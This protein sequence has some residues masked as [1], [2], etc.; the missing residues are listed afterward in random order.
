MKVYRIN[1]RSILICLALLLAFTI[2]S[3]GQEEYSYNYSEIADHPRLLLNRSGEQTVKTVVKSTPE[4]KKINDYI[5]EQSDVIL[6]QK[7]VH[8]EKRGKRLLWVS[9]IALT[10]LYYLSYS[11]RITGETKYLERAELELNT[12]ADFESWNPSHFLDIGEMTMAVAIAY[13]WL[14]DGLKEETKKNVREAIVEK[15][16][17]PSYIEKY[18]WFLNKHSN[19]NS[20]CNAGLVFG[21]LAIMEDEPEQSIAII[22]RALVSNRLP[23]EVFAPDGNY[24]EGP[25]Y[26][27]Y[28]TSF[29]VMLIAALESALGSDNGLSQAPGFMRTAEYI[30]F[31]SGPSG[32]Y[33]NYYDC[34][35]E[36][37]ARSSIFWFA[38]KLNNPSLVYQELAM[39]RD[40]GYTKKVSSDIERIL[41]N[42]IVFGRN[43]NLENIPK[44]NVKTFTGHGITPVTIVRTNWEGTKGKYMGIKGGSASDGHSHMDQGTFVYDVG[45][46]RWAMDLGLQSYGTL[47]SEGVD[48]WSMTQNSQR[49]DVFRYNNLNHNTISINGQKHNIEGRAKIVETYDDGDELGAKVDLTDV[50]NLNNEVKNATRKVTIVKDSYLKVEDIIEANEEAVKIRWNMVTPSKAEKVNKNTIRL[51]QKG[52][53]MFLKVQSKTSFKIAIRESENPSTVKCDFT[54]RKYEDYNHKNIG[55]V[56]VGFDAEVP[57]GE[58]AKFTVTLTEGPSDIKLKK[59]TIV[60]DAPDPSTASEGDNFFMDVSPF[61]IDGDGYVFAKE[62][63]DWTPYGMVSIPSAV[64]KSFSFII[65]AKRIEDSGLVDAGID[66]AANGQLGIRGGEN[67]GIENNEGYIFGL[68]LSEIDPSVTFELTKIQLTFFDRTESCIIVNRQEA[69]RMKSLSGGDKSN[70]AFVKVTANSEKE[71]TDISD[72]N[73]VVKGGKKYNEIASVFST[74]G[75]SYRIAAFEFRVTEN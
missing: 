45:R 12:I 37:T 28:G 54:N 68:D 21:A 3:K 69:G 29:Q 5:I 4:F 65:S 57:A 61:G 74:G 64:D 50:L 46:N 59:N 60:L 39:I 2:K 30:V 53:T 51:S 73:I 10:R 6:S 22:E 56:M 19:W 71:F 67:N 41:P 1:Q 75:G 36:Q 47:E 62:K 8:F 42:A 58:K 31:A 27:N 38:D 23:L 13:D 18:S 24:P 44:P 25:G 26:W 9:R 17:K 63:P 48:L 43:I 7:P 16:F 20:V 34:G 52:K 35:R 66:R 49:W 11:Y 15:A 33:F 70:A 32:E 40:G 72:L 55:T 14:F